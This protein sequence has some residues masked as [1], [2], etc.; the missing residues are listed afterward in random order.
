MTQGP[1]QYP[2]PLRRSLYRLSRRSLPWKIS[3]FV[4]YN[5]LLSIYY[6]TDGQYGRSFF[7]FT[8]CHCLGGKFYPTDLFGVHSTVEIGSPKDPPFTGSPF[9]STFQGFSTVKLRVFEI[10]SV[11]PPLPSLVTSLHDPWALPWVFCP[12]TPTSI[13]KT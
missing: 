10:P 8:V 1:W 9:V 4:C 11:T 2:R 3:L 12:E 13:P 6:F 5:H 7:L